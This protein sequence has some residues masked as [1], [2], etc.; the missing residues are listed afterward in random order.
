MIKFFPVGNG[1]GKFPVSLKSGCHGD[2]PWCILASELRPA[3]WQRDAGFPFP[4][5]QPEK[6]VN[7]KGYL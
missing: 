1:S 7:L 6:A 5:F 3:D 2:T 4:L